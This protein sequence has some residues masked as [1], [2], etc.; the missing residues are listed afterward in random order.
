MKNL[1][2]PVAVGLGAIAEFRQ[3]Y[4]LIDKSQ[5][6]SLRLPSPADEERIT[7]RKSFLI[8]SHSLYEKSLLFQKGIRFLDN[9]EIILY[10]IK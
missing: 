8:T 2:K 7:V 5:S 10:I 6:V 3:I 4:S 1:L 9:S